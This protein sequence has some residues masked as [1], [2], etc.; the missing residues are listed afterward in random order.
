MP[1]DYHIDSA[2]QAGFIRLTGYIDADQVKDAANQMY[3][4]PRWESHYVSLWDFRET[5]EVDIS[6]E[7]SKA[8]I[9]QKLERDMEG[10]HRGKIA[11]VINRE[12]ITDWGRFIEI[13][14][15]TSERRMKTFS[16]QKEAWAWLEVAEGIGAWQEIQKVLSAGS[17][18]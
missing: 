16:S 18:H 17:G 5:K 10:R 4:D 2:L 7:G 13:S 6:L 1:F 3:D 15:S 12:A 11:A 14:A 8:I 9:Q